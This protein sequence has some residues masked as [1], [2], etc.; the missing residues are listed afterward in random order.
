MTALHVTS[1]EVPQIDSGDWI[2]VD[3]A[4]A[5]LGV[6]TRT[7]YTMIKAGRVPAPYRLSQRRVRYSEHEFREWLT[8]QRAAARLVAAG[9]VA[10]SF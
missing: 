10:P 9:G 2:T 5:L 8:A 6:S 7:F 4:A 1:S 3:H